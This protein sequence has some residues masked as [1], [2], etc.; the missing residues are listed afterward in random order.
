MD[1]ELTDEEIYNLILVTIDQVQKNLP[2]PENG[3]ELK[4]LAGELNMEPNEVKKYIQELK[5][6][7]AVSWRFD[8]TRGGQFFINP[9][10]KTLEN[11]E[12]LN[13]LTVSETAKIILTK[14]YDFYKRAGYDSSIQLESATIGSVIGLNNFS[15]INSALEI[16]E[17]EG[18]IKSPAVM[19]NNTIYLL[20]AKGINMIESKPEK[21]LMNSGGTIIVN[22][23]DGNVAINS[24]NVNQ[25]ISA[26]ELQQYFGILEKLI[27]E[28]LKEQEKS[29]ALNDLETV[30]EL[31][32]IEPPK[33]HLIQRILNN[34]DKLPI[35]IEIVK[36][37]REFF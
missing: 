33:T 6:K 19:R 5:I 25:T 30:K 22:N 15:K 2:F 31:A 9:T 37:I 29:D 7:R 27:T 11:F 10:E 23:T 17:D 18:L 32:K 35:L 3:A 14:S 16:L 12:K 26:N 28:N 20:S 1:I 4:F 36:K 13:E 8:E 24:N 34:L 21:Q